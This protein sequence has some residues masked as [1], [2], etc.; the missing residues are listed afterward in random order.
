MSTAAALAPRPSLRG[1]SN[2]R[3]DCRN[4]YVIGAGQTTEQRNAHSGRWSGTSRAV[5]QRPRLPALGLN[6]DKLKGFATARN[7]DLLNVPDPGRVKL[8]VD[9]GLDA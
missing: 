9:A 7:G 2:P 1:R 3:D 5:A 8:V 6:A 4:S